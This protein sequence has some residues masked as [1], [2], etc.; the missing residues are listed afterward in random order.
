MIEIIIKDLKMPVDNNGLGY[1]NDCGGSSGSATGGSSTVNTDQFAEKSK[2]EAISLSKNGTTISLK[3]YDGSTDDIEIT[4]DTHTWDSTNRVLTIH[5]ADGNDITIDIGNSVDVLDEDNPPEYDS[6]TKQ[7]TFTW[8]NG[9]Q[10][11]MNVGDL[12]TVSTDDTIDGDGTATSPLKVIPSSD[13]GNS[14]KRGSDGRLYVEAVSD[15]KHEDIFSGDGTDIDPLDLEFSSDTENLAKKGSDGKLYVEQLK[16][17]GAITG[18]GL[19]GDEF[20]IFISRDTKNIIVKGTDSGLYVE[21]EIDDSTTIDDKSWSSK[22]IDNELDRHLR[23]ISYS[24]SNFTNVCNSNIDNRLI[25]EWIKEPKSSDNTPNTLLTSL[26]VAMAI[27]DIKSDLDLT[28]DLTLIELDGS[29][30]VNPSVID[31]AYYL[32]YNRSTSTTP[33]LVMETLTKA[34][35]PANY[36]KVWD[37][38]YIGYS[39]SDPDNRVVVGEDGIIYIAQRD[40]IPKDRNPIDDDGTN[41]LP[42][43]KERGEFV[44]GSETYIGLPDK[45]LDGTLLRENDH[46]FLTKN[47]I[48][49]G[50]DFHPDYPAGIYTY[51]ISNSSWELKEELDPIGKDS[52]FLK[53]SDVNP[54]K[55]G[56]PTITEIKNAINGKDYSRAVIYY[57]GT[58]TDD[59][60]TTLFTYY[61]DRDGEVIPLGKKQDERLHLFAKD[62]DINPAIV[63]NP[64]LDEIKTYAVN[65]SIKD[66]FITYNGRDTDDGDYTRVYHIDDNE[67]ILLVERKKDP[68]RNPF[69]EITVDGTHTI[70]D[71]LL[72][73][74][75]TDSTLT[76]KDKDDNLI[77]DES[78]NSTYQDLEYMLY[79][80]NNYIGESIVEY[81]VTH[82]GIE[83]PA[84]KLIAET[85]N[86]L[87]IDLSDTLAFN[88]LDDGDSIVIRRVK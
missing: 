62:S 8:T 70:R 1:C 7:I 18:T 84:T 30:V 9:H 39:S 2:T 32:I 12:V 56:R 10:T 55:D 73:L 76:L 87:K 81:V 49:A 38:D 48:G 24:D 44:G 69:I 85:N 57:N 26:R 58:D 33:E 36:I 6:T 60:D 80:D 59:K 45:R 46:A 35:K 42:A 47:D 64:T 31:A 68:V 13:S 79:I 23:F 22:K 52:I 14:L 34:G 41:W 66:R 74:E 67:N 83:I 78:T 43:I 3:R 72:Y 82:N 29:E 53:D 21:T 77:A 27:D 63:G 16:A 25:K 19:S 15:V 11:V 28:G 51:N 88:Y 4:G 17:K 86:K 61:V 54:Q 5:E 37:K 75:W 50:D 40:T 65:S 20:D 71:Y